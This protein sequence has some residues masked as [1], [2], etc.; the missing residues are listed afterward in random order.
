MS[1]AEAERKVSIQRIASTNVLEA[2]GKDDVNGLKAQYPRLLFLSLVL[3]IYK[4]LYSNIDD[5][6]NVS[7]E[8][9]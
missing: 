5:C 7:S 4:F 2:R 6:N 8:K 1:C 9:Q 3:A